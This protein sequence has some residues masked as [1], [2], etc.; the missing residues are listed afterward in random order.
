MTLRLGRVAASTLDETEKAIQRVL[1]DGRGHLT[2]EIAYAIR[3]T[4]RAT[5]TRL[6]RLVGRGFV[7]EVGTS[8]QDPKRQYF[9]SS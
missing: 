4:P 2:S 6:L 7:R 1:R 9:L 3:L 5:R 8:P